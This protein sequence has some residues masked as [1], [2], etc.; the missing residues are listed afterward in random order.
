VKLTKATRLQI[1]A[2][3]RALLA[4]LERDVGD[5]PGGPTLRIMLD[6]AD[7]AS[8]MIEAGEEGPVR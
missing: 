7:L 5:E 6:S 2:N 3:A 4:S 8:A 1:L